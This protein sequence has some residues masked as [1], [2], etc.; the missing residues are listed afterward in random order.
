MNGEMTLQALRTTGLVG[1]GDFVAAAHLII[2]S[3][4]SVGATFTV[5][6]NIDGKRL[7]TL[8]YGV[9]FKRVPHLRKAGNAVVPYTVVMLYA[10]WVQ[11]VSANME[12]NEQAIWAVGNKV[13][14]KSVYKPYTIQEAEN[15]NNYFGGSPLSSSMSGVGA[16][17]GDTDTADIDSI[18]TIPD[19]L[20]EGMSGTPAP[21]TVTWPV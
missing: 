5:V 6:E 1:T 11:G 2:A 21:S 15:Q 16:N 3:K 19:P 20:A 12:V 7:V 13:G 9:S 10:G 4:D 18:A 17:N 14:L 8:F